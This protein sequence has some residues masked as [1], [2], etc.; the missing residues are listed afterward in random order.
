MGFRVRIQGADSGCGFRVGIKG[1]GFWVR[2]QVLELKSGLRVTNQGQDSGSKF[3]VG[4]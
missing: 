3:R 2:I 1:S 4:I